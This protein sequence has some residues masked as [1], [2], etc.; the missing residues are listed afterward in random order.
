MSSLEIGLIG[1]EDPSLRPHL[2]VPRALALAGTAAAITVRATWLPTD[3]PAVRDASTLARFAGLWCV[4][5]SPYR[6]LEGALAAIAFARREHTP[7]LGT[8]GG[9]Q[10]ALIEHARA[11]LGLADADHAESN[12]HAATPLI[13]P[14]SCSL[15]GASATIELRP[16]SRIAQAYGELRATE[17]FYCR[18]GLNPAYRSQL[19]QGPLRIVG[20]DSDGEPRAVERTDQTFFVATLFQPELSAFT[21][22]AH[23]L[24]IAFVRAAAA[25]RSGG[26]D[27]SAHQS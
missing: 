6:S 12:P 1:D 22:R 3:G 21:D 25:A 10:H 9:F 20:V 26:A 19:E 16:G 17:G 15:V 14:L 24:V 5:G 23:P 7:F 18:Y 27:G 8:C 2:A 13:A 11:E 4:P